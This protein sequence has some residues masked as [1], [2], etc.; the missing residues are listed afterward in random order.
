MA[1][2]AVTVLAS[3]A[4]TATATSEVVRNGL[5]ARGVMLLLNVTAQTDTPNISAL[6]L[7][8]K[9]GSTWTTVYSFTGLTI[10]AA[11]QK[12]FLIYPGAAS[13][14]GWTAAPLQGPCP[15]E[16]KIVVTH[17]DADSITYSLTAE[18]LA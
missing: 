18:F 14:A 17:D 15:G 8:V 4:R 9:V 5:G 3:E 2:D 7:Q 10:N 16:F 6:A 12:T 13:A 11:G 1:Y